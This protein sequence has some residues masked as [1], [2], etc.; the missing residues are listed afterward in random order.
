M[1][2]TLLV[3]KGGGPGAYNFPYNP[4]SVTW[5]YHQQTSVV[6]TKGGRVIQLLGLS[7]DGLVVQIHLGSRSEFQHFI[8]F[9]RDLMA[10][11]TSDL[12][13]PRNAE[14]SYSKRG[15]NFQVYVQSLDISDSLE[16]VSFPVSLTLAVRDNEDLF[17]V[18]KTLQTEALTRL[19]EGVGYVNGKY[20]DPTAEFNQEHADEALSYSYDESAA[21]S[22]TQNQPASGSASSA[23]AFA[24]AAIGTPYV[25]GGASAAGYD[26][27]G[28]VM[29][30][31]R[32]QGKSL[33]RTAAQQYAATTSQKIPYSQ[34]QPGDLLFWWGSR[35]VSHV[36]I[37]VGNNR[38]IHA[39]V[40]GQTVK[41]VNVYFTGM[42]PYV[43]RV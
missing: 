34:A 18:R 3:T 13:Q 1:S 40:P 36:A 32:T 4:D 14:F 26:C 5:R 41:E 17:P 8:R 9:I 25:W 2:G 28:L 10:W 39:P 15:W 7:I 11:Q 22:P 12:N 19:R 31:Y 6:E 38:M 29:C 23:I 35:G 24:R 16:N 43:G 21:N 33:P 27:S 37:Y 42:M 20:S 30:A